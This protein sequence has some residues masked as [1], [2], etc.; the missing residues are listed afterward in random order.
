MDHTDAPGFYTND[1]RIWNTLFEDIP[2]QWKQIPPSQEMQDCLE[3]FQHHN[4]SNV[5]D[6]GCGVGVW[7]M[8]LSKAG[9]R[10]K[11]VDFSQ[12][13]IDFAAGW[14]REEKQEIEFRCAP[15]TSEAFPTERFD[16]V[17]AA[18]ILD[19]ISRQE[20][21]VVLNHL[22]T[23]LGNEGLLYCLF[24]PAMTVEE[25][26]QLELSDNPTKGITHIL[27]T[28]EELRRLFPGFD[29]L[30]FK[31]YTHG[32]RGLFLQKRARDGS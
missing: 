9:L 31:R 7:A 17:V 30:A 28:D 22:E 25:L 2:P 5:L 32:F 13:A 27:Y 10:L 4:V 23:S 1:H 18:K 19:N 3:F 11:G 14:A 15:V 20:F 6:L 29:L 8:Y 26:E 21:A 12:N 16:A 24:N